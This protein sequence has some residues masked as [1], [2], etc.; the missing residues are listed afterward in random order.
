[1]V[2]IIYHSIAHRQFLFGRK[3][4][5]NVRIE[6]HRSSSALA[7]A[8]EPAA[9][10]AAAAVAASA[11]YCTI[12]S[13]LTSSETYWIGKRVYDGFFLHRS[14]ESLMKIDG[15]QMEKQFLFSATISFKSKPMDN[16]EYCRQDKN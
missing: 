9:P 3:S 10:A 14:N 6:S 12:V 15:T 16:D 11:L 13:S 1:M 8:T 7:A 5:I 4:V 2:I